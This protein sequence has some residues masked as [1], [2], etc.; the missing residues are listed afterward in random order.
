LALMDIGKA[1][2]ANFNSI[3]DQISKLTE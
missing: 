2:Q 1:G 3:I